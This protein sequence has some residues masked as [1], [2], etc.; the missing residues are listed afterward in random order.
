MNHIWSATKQRLHPQSVAEIS[1]HS[2]LS[3]DR[4]R[5]CGTSSGSRHKDVCRHFLKQA[6][7]CPCSVQK[8]F[9]RDR[10]CRGR[11]KPGCRIMVNIDHLSRLLVM[12]PTLKQIIT[13]I[14]VVLRR[15]HWH[16][17]RSQKPTLLRW[18]HSSTTASHLLQHHQ[19][20]N[21]RQPAVIS[22]MGLF[23]QP[24]PCLSSLCLYSVCCVL[25]E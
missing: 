9:S 12:P 10:C 13:L 16:S 6:P 20:H 22:P 11:S 24:V 23:W 21:L 25:G 15:C 18:T 3:G 1:R 7:Q 5:Q 2:V 4:I 14:A 19:T 17:H 8:R